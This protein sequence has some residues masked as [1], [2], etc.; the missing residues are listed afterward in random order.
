MD[1]GGVI[2]DDVELAD[3]I[4]EGDAGEVQEP[5]S[6]VGR[7]LDEGVVAEIAETT[8]GRSDGLRTRKALVG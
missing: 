5:S 1:G 3:V 8:V 2:A 6:E 7:V 4:A